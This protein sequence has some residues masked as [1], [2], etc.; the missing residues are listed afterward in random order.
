MQA[1]QVKEAATQ[2]LARVHQKLVPQLR[3]P[4]LLLMWPKFGLLR[5]MWFWIR[6]AVR[7]SFWPSHTLKA[8]RPTS[9]DERH[10]T[11]QAHRHEWP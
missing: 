11:S 1:L 8:Q 9:R 6:H 4:D 3:R 2:T 7:D 5:L 10:V